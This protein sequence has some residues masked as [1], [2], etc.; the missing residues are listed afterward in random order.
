ML[1]LS[2]EELSDLLAPCP[3]LVVPEFCLLSTTQVIVGL[4]EAAIF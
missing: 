2:Q 3:L 1:V 4:G